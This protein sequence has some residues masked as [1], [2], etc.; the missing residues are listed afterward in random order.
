[1]NTNKNIDR[2]NNLCLKQ[3]AELSQMRYSARAKGDENVYCKFTRRNAPLPTL[4][5]K[6]PNEGA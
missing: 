3:R 2:I 5:R 6:E 1:M 4:A